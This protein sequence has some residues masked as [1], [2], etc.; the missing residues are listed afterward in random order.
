[1]WAARYGATLVVTLP[2][3]PAFLDRPYEP[4]PYRPVSHRFWNEVYLDPTRTPEFRRSKSLRH[5]VQG[6]RFRERVARL[7]RRESVDFR[8]VARLKRGVVEQMLDEFVRAPL[9]RRR[10]FRR[11]LETTPGVDDY[12]RFRAS[13]ESDPARGAAYH[14]FAQWLV[15]EQLRQ[16]E[17]RLRRRGVILGLDLPLGTHPRGFD[18]QREARSYAS[19]IRI[20]SPPDPGVPRGQDWNIPSFDPDRLRNSGYR[21]FADALRHQFEVAGLL[22]IDHVL[23]FHRLFWIPA[24]AAPRAG[25][26]VR[27]PARDLYAV[28]L[29]EAAR[30]NAIVVGE[31]LG[32]VPPGLRSELRRR[33]LLALY[34]AE[35]EWDGPGRPRAIPRECTASLNT[36]DHLPF[37]GYWVERVRAGRPPALGDGFPPTN[38]PASEAFRLATERLARSPARFVVVNTEDLWGETRPQNVPGE[39]GANFTRRFRID[40]ATLRRNPRVAE[41]LSTLDALRRRRYVG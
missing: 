22:R 21:P 15:D 30:A 19:G 29:A 5:R 17:R 4:S 28:L 38:V 23:G 11:F 20:G 27:F 3:L 14:R 24:G 25:A 40:L 10:A 12:A 34:V 26:Y 41:L 33:G 2:L 31:D 37:A 35:L 39:R 32:T 13:G 1:M 7:E 36:H 8:S 6:R 18:V 9:S 16:V